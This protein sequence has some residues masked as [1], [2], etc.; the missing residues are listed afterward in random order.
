MEEIFDRCLLNGSTKLYFEEFEKAIIIAS[1]LFFPG[2]HAAC[3]YTSLVD[4]AI[5]FLPSIRSA[6]FPDTNLERLANIADTVLEKG[7]VCTFRPPSVYCAACTWPEDHIGH[8]PP[9]TRR[10]SPKRATSPVELLS[11]PVRTSEVSIKP[12]LVLPPVSPGS[13]KACKDPAE[14]AF[15]PSPNRQ[16]KPSQPL[17]VQDEEELIPPPP[18]KSDTHQIACDF[19]DSLMRHFGSREVAFQFLDSATG[20]C[21]GQI[22]ATKFRYCWKS[23]GFTGDMRSVFPYLDVD[24][25]GVINETDFKSWRAIREKQ[26]EQRILV[27]L[28]NSS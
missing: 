2:T 16:R 12:T 21:T 6:H 11:D 14:G 18:V 24:G 20:K 17:R 13:D 26:K 8:R 19:D 9:R 27:N 5:I 23:L 25:D 1:M 3:A 22:S 4:Q 10:R 28:P 7:T 15:R